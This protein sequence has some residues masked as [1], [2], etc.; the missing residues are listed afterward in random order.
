M[1][2]LTQTTYPPAQI[3]SLVNG[4]TANPSTVTVTQQVTERYVYDE[5]GNVVQSFDKNGHFTLSYFDVKGHKIAS[6]DAA[7]YLTEWDYDEQG[8]V[9]EQRAYTQPLN[10]S[11]LSASTRP[12]PPSGDVYVTDIQY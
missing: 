1:G 10:L 3:T 6:V 2:R 11:S 5:F 7:G 8:E 9:I 12:T 4:G